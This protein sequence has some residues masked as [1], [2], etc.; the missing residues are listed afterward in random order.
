MLNISSYAYF[1]LYIFL[2]RHLFRYCAHFWMRFCFLNVNSSLYILHTDASSDVCF[3]NIFFH[4]FICFIILL[5]VY[6][7]RQILNLIKSNSSNFLVSWI[8]SLVLYLKAYHQTQSHI[9]FFLWF[10]LKVL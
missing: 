9:E 7:A 2:L 1:H 5:T 6:F 10:L 8:K 3:T 4:C